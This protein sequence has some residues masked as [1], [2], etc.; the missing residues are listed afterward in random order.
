MNCRCDSFWSPSD[1]PCRLARAPE[2]ALCGVEGRDP[3]P[4]HQP[5]ISDDYVWPY[6]GLFE[7][8]DDS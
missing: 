6:T 7:E 1:K 5:P 4:P 8:Q 2:K 3:L